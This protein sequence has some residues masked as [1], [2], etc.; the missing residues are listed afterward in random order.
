MYEFELVVNGN[1]EC[2]FGGK[3]E[4]EVLARYEHLSRLLD[5]GDWDI[6]AYVTYP[7]RVDM[8]IAE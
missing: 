6:D 7:R 5:D 1:V 3:T 4:L 8:A 2:V